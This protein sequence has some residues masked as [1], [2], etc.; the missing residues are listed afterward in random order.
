MF[1]DKTSILNNLFLKSDD[2]IYFSVYDKF[3]HVSRSIRISCT[4]LEISLICL[5]LKYNIEYKANILYN[6]NKLELIN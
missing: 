6:E 3:M 1:F 2:V 5:H 4:N